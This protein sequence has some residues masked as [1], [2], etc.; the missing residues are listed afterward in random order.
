MA[1]LRV[2][3]SIFFLF[4]LTVLLL[5]LLH[6]CSLNQTHL[7]LI[8]SSITSFDYMQTNYTTPQISPAPAPAP[9]PAMAGAPL[10][11]LNVRVSSMVK[12]RL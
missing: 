7:S 5:L 12:M 9:A 8:F 4:P 3:P 11:P 2:H 6:F 1:T 10:S